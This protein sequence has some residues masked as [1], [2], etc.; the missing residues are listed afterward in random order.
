M[1]NTETEQPQEVVKP[2]RTYKKRTPKV[3]QET[4]TDEVAAAP[5]T[6]AKA[7][8]KRVVR[9]KTVRAEE[10]NVAV[11]D[12]D[13]KKLARK[14][15]TRKVSV[16]EVASPAPT[17]DKE[18]TSETEAKP[19][20]KRATRTKKTEAEVPSEQ[21]QENPVT[22]KKTTRRKK[23]QPEA[24]VAEETP[25][26]PKRTYKK[27]A[28]L[29]VAKP[30]EAPLASAETPAET[31]AVAEVAPAAEERVSSEGDTDFFGEKVFDPAV[32]KR[33][34]IA[35]KKALVAASE[36]LHKVLADAGMGS[37]R[38]MEQLILEGRVSVN[39]TPAF[40]GQRIF[41]ADVVRLNGKIVKRD[42]T[43]DGKK[44]P[45]RVLV[46]HK[47]T[48]EIVSM[49]DP[50][51]RPTVFDHLP[52]V[53]GGRWIAVGRLDFN[54]EGLLLFTTSGELANRL[55]HPRYQIEREYAVRAVGEMT[56]E[57]REALLSGVELEDGPAHFATIEDKGGDGA[58][59]WYVVRLSEGR[60]REVR[61]MF[62]AVG[63]T[64]SRLI[65]VRYGAVT[66]PKTLVRGASMELKSDWI[67][68]WM[69]ELNI[70]AEELSQQP[71][72]EFK[73]R[74]KLDN[75]KRSEKSRY[76][77]RERGLGRGID[78][79]TSTV[80]YLANGS[81]G[82]TSHSIARRI[83][84]IDAMMPNSLRNEGFGK[85]FAKKHRFGK[86]RF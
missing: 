48:G 45:P 52:R 12:G 41:P 34:K 43:A 82:E 54:T 61:R 26:K 71:K 33:G 78:P 62:E 31:P 35:A 4:V 3:T 56:P 28:A 67:D 30:S 55:M 65:R 40:L 23:V 49:D 8:K 5:D 44:K 68:A 25:I 14:R 66:L 2:K 46:Y 29:V 13:D 38:D 64:V 10:A 7:P 22:E 21:M 79:L 83:G 63:L 74:S 19:V 17:E 60:N 37:R 39:G 47:P 69:N 18:V 32:A 75:K 20:R 73:K 27:K 11:T 85:K 51:G 80:H 86:K 81:M 50:E 1:T 77:A 70:V 16:K 42:V 72:K 24:E 59:R 36:K 84:A 9:K 15:T 6:E 53:S 76:G 57:G 58:N